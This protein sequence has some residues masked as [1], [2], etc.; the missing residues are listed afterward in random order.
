LAGVLLALGVAALYFLKP[1][2]QRLKKVVATAY[3]YF[4]LALRM[5]GAALSTAIIEVVLV[6]A[7]IERWRS[8]QSPDDENYYSQL[9][10]RLKSARNRARDRI[11]AERAKLGAEITE[12]QPEQK[13]Q[14]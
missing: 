14:Q 3:A 7:R 9:A 4:L 13:V 1:L 8:S 12:Q 10:E 6:I 5:L 11:A 2:V